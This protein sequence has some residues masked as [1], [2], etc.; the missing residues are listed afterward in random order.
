M[1]FFMDINLQ[2]YLNR[3]FKLNSLL[4]FKFLEVISFTDSNKQ[5]LVLAH[6]AFKGIV[7]IFLSVFYVPVIVMSGQCLSCCS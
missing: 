1:F 3:G 5:C 2:L 6:F 7:E 4:R